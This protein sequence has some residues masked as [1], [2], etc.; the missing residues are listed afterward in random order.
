MGSQGTDQS[1]TED[2]R[3]PGV[4]AGEWPVIGGA[5]ARGHRGGVAGDWAGL[6]GQACGQVTI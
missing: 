2:G 6:P 4:T 5:G 1:P 3:V